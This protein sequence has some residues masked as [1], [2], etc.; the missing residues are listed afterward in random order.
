MTE[1]LGKRDRYRI[2]MKWLT[3]AYFVAAIQI[4]VLI[5]ML[6]NPAL[7]KFYVTTRNGDV[8]PVQPLSA[9]IVT[10]KYI[11]SWAGMRAQAAFT[12]DFVKYAKE[13]DA[14]QPYFTDRGWSQFHNA[15]V[16][17]NIV[18]SLQSEK[19]VVTSV[20]TSTPVI[21]KQGVLDGAYSWR[22][23][24]PLLVSFVSASDNTKRN[25]TVTLVIHRVPVMD[26]KNGIQIDYFIAR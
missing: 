10:S 15:I 4:I 7:G 9:P 5:V 21:L 1:Y 11:S 12:L 6:I 20:V 18:D 19:M 13:L 3:I 2:L 16:K 22:V 8:V 14:L 26:V 17:A 24:V 25:L 23:K